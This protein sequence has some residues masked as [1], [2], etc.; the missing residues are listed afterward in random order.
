MSYTSLVRMGQHSINLSMYQKPEILTGGCKF[1]TV[2]ARFNILID[3]RCRF[4][5]S[6]AAFPLFPDLLDRQPSVCTP[7]AHS[8][9]EGGL[10]GIPCWWLGAFRYWS[11]SG[12]GVT[13][14]EGLLRAGKV[15]RAKGADVPP[16][17]ATLSPLQFAHA[18]DSR[19][20]NN[21]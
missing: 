16:P 1:S 20:A 13:L 6:D 11:G 8:V 4:L 9:S 21:Q 17:D 15:S 10:W 19:G 18:G 3:I 14:R 5:F 2:S 12:R 7:E